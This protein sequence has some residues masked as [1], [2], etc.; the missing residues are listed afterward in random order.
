MTVHLGQKIQ[1]R[2][3]VMRGFREY[4]VAADRPVIGRAC[5]QWRRG[6]FEQWRVNHGR[7][8]FVHKYILFPP[9]A[10][11]RS[12]ARGRKVEGDAAIQAF[13]HLVSAIKALI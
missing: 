12:A 11:S 3:F 4:L 9:S 5:G 13:M 1:P 2:D 6:I 8:D 7:L 10:A